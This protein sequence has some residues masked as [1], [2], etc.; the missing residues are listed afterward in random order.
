MYCAICGSRSE[1][2]AICSH[3]T[4]Q[5]SV[6]NNNLILNLKK[7]PFFFFRNYCLNCLTIW[8]SKWEDLIGN[9]SWLCFLCD[10]FNDILDR[11][12]SRTMLTVHYDWMNR[13]SFHWSFLDNNHNSTMMILWL[14]IH[15]FFS[16]RFC[17]FTNLVPLLLQEP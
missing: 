11:E 13:V 15:V 2:R 3:L 16:R 12:S 17:A 4:C 6:I 1:E 5:R 8:L 7:K 10:E 14:L 9:S